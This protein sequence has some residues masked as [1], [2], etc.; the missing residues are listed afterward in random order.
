MTRF[1][2]A[3]ACALLATTGLCQAAG[4]PVATASE[5]LWYGAAWYPEQWK[6]ADWEK[7]LKLMEAAGVNVVRI[8][9]FAWST[10]EPTEGT[11]DFAWMDRAIRMAEKH[12]IKVVIGTPTD[13]PPAWLTQKYPETLR[14]DGNGQRA[15]HGA[16]RQF[17]YSSPL[18]RKMSREIVRRMAERYGHDPNVIGWQI[19]NEY[20]EESFDPATQAM[21]LAQIDG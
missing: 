4:G 20:T 19:D 15:E 5:R 2:A 12:H 18:Y 6:E 8:G 11:Y 1:A 9:E 17:S 21:F 16:R 14:I 10:M 7:D 3:F 13:T